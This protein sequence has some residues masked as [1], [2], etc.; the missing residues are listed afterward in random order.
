M[1]IAASSLSVFLLFAAFPLTAYAA[2]K[3]KI[4]DEDGTYKTVAVKSAK[5]C[6]NLCAADSSICR[7][8]MLME[9]ITIMNG[10]KSSKMQCHLNNGLSATS[11]FEITPP[12]PLDLNVAVAELNAYRAENGLKPIALSDKLNRAS[13]V[14]A[15]DLAKH[16]IAAHIGTDGSTHSERVQRQGYYFQII[17]E[18]VATGQKSWNQVFQAWKDS[19]GHNKNLLAKGVEDF[20]IAIVYEPTTTYTTYWT[21]LVG[22]PLPR[23]EHPPE[24]MTIEQKAILDIQ[25]R[26]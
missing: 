24:A 1:R 2:E 18:N 11:P 21:M 26:E 17:A 15:K 10:K 19:P 12:A 14:H 4:P 16:G 22:S 13:D 20:G 23:F 6:T 9:E 7:G 5:E 25:N 8:S 3:I